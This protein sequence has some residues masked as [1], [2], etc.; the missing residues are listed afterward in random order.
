MD[1]QLTFTDFQ[2]MGEY[3]DARTF[4][5]ENPEFWDLLVEWAHVDH[6]AGRACSMQLYIELGRRPELRPAG[7]TRVAGTYLINHNL[8]SALERLMM[9]DYPYLVFNIRKSR[10]DGP[11]IPSARPAVPRA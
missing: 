8:R 4:R 9:L 6:N 5:A 10:C 11:M 3:K 2:G 1:G 7:F